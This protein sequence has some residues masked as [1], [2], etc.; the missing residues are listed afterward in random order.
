MVMRLIINADDFYDNNAFK[1]A[2][3]FLKSNF[4]GTKNRREAAKFFWR[5]KVYPPPKKH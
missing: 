4:S 5:Q 3:D 1:N 2:A